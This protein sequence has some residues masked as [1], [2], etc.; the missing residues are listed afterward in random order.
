MGLWV[1][2]V[3]V[4]GGLVGADGGWGCRIASCETH[5]NV[6][7]PGSGGVVSVVGAGCEWGC[8]CCCCSAPRWSNCV[9]CQT[10]CPRG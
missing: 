6:V 10:V 3:Q 9:S 5:E 4:V 7:G 8:G 2:W 1:L